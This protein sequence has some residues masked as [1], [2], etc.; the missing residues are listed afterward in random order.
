MGRNDSQ[1]FF[2]RGKKQLIMNSKTLFPLHNRWS[3]RMRILSLVLMLGLFCAGNSY[4]IGKDKKVEQYEKSVKDLFV[5]DRWEEG[6][7]ILR[8]GLRLYPESSE[9]NG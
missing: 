3:Y 7:K 6:M 8:E 9:L 5:D 4:G 1:G 2:R